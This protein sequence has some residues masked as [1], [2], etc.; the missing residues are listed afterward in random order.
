MPTPSAAGRTA[1]ANAGTYLRRWRKSRGVSQMSVALECGVSARHLSFVETGRARPSQQL[2]VHLA[3]YFQVSQ[4]ELNLCLLAAGHAP[5]RAMLDAEPLTPALE[6]LLEHHDPNPAFVFDADRRMRRL[7]RGGQWLCS[8]VMPRLWSKVTCPDVGVDMI[9][10]LAH[11]DG[12]LSHMRDAQAIGAGMTEQLRV[13]QITNP[14]LEARIATLERSLAERF[15]QWPPDVPEPRAEPTFQMTFDTRLGP[16]S[17]F[18][19]QGVVGIPE[20]VTGGKLR[21]ELWYP[22]DTQTRAVTLAHVAQTDETVHTP[23]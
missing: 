8:L 6:R 18:T 11:P 21:T 4:S 7:N 17:Y 22:T 1:T 19:V 10:A 2:L 16:L 20:H 13:E 14:H 3:R 12:L 9:E 15:D 23:G 5:V